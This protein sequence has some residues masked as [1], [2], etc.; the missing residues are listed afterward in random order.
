MKGEKMGK[1]ILTIIISFIVGLFGMV[2]GLEFF[3]GFPSL[4]PVMAIATAGGLIVFFN[5]KN[6][7]YDCSFVRDP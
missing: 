5:E 4:G 2:V 1:A 6:N 3:G 7:F